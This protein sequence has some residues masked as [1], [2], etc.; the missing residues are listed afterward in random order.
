MLNAHDIYELH[1]VTG[2]LA[3]GLD[4]GAQTV[5]G[6]PL[7]VAQ[8]LAE[9]R[10]QMRSLPG[11]IDNLNESFERFLTVSTALKRMIELAD[12]ASVEM[13]EEEREGLEE[14]F[15]NLAKIVAADAGRQYY[16]GPALSLKTQGH[17]WAA[18]KIIRYMEPVMANVEKELAEQKDLIYEVVTETVNFLNV[19]AE[20][21]PESEGIGHLGQLIDSASKYCPVPLAPAVGPAGALH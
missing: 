19:V 18:A 21:Y 2:I 11:V 8:T 7:E 5:L 3:G 6:V 20:C 14:E 4:R 1:Q 15:V 13:G 16:A 9:A 17:A 10:E 12:A